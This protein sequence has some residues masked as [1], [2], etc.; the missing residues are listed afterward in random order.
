MQ[1]DP[2][3]ICI[4]RLAGIEF[5][6]IAQFIKRLIGSFKPNKCQAE[7]MMK[8]GI[9]RRGKE[10]GPQHALAV[11]FSPDRPVKIGEVG[12]C[13]RILWTQAQR[14]FVFGLR[15][16]WTAA[17]RKETSKRRARFRPIGIE[18]LST[19]ELGRRALKPFTVGGRLV[20]SR[21][22]GEQRGC[23][24]AYAAAGIG[25]KRR[26]KRP[27]LSARYA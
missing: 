25:E 26:S 19:D 16:G 23:P 8:A 17:L 21:N 9:S 12:G 2:V 4:S 1:S 24:D 5:G 18:A 22:H 27:N 7:R 6:G 3:D 20:R 15:F 10:R 13:G 11:G 14:S